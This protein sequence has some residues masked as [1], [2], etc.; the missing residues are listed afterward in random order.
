MTKFEKMP[1]WDLSEYYN[2]TDDKKIDEDIALYAKK[3]NDFAL[4][5]RGKVAKLDAEA[6]WARLKR[7]RRWI[8][9]PQHLAVLPALIHPRN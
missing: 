2:G 6:F 9:L 7:L 1:E 4:K 8:E 5:Y 3:A